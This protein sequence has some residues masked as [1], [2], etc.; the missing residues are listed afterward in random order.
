MAEKSQIQAKIDA[1]VDG[2][3]NPVASEREISQ[4][5]L[6]EQFSENDTDDNGTGAFTTASNVLLDYQ[7]FLK[8]SGNQV[9]Y[10]IMLRNNAGFV[11][12]ASPTVPV[13]IFDWKDTKYTPNVF[14][15][16][17]IAVY[18]GS[19]SY[20][21]YVDNIGVYL[22]TSLPPTGVGVFYESSMNLY[23]TRTL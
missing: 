22:Y 17:I 4:N 3:D 6:D 10:K 11:I 19:Q 13:K 7:L 20:K 12:S 18:L 23:M 1:R 2:G 16:T 14:N 5:F 15:N 21:L 9:M 8:K